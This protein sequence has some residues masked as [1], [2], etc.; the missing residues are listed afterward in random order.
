MNTHAH[1]GPLALLCV[2]LHPVT[3]NLYFDVDL[4][5]IMKCYLR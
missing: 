4:T 3:C 5:M 1:H 2:A